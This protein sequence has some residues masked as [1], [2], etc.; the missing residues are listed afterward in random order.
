MRV[1]INALSARHGG[2]QTYLNYL[3]GQL[4]DCPAEVVYVLTHG[5]LDLPDHP[6]VKAIRPTWPALNPLARTVG[7]KLRLPR[8]LRDLSI[9]ILFCPGG[10][11]A[12]RPPPGC[13]VVSMFQNMLPFD[14]GQAFR[15]GFRLIT[16]RLVLLRRV[17]LDGMRKADLTIFISDHARDVIRALGGIRPQ[18]P[19]IPHGLSRQFK[20][21]PER[22]PPRSPAAPPRPY[23][24][25][26]SLLDP[27][28][29]HLEVVQ[30][31][32]LLRQRRPDV[33]DLV[34]VGKADTP[35][36]ASVRR[37]IQHAGLAHA[38]HVLG[39]V[40]HGD[41]PALHAHAVVNLFASSCE[42]CPN[43]LIEA[44]G[45]GRP[46]AVSD[47]QPMP[48]FALDAVEYFDPRSPA[49]IADALGRLL[50][51]PARAEALGG[52]ARA[53]AH[54]HDWQATARRTWDA[55]GGL[56]AAGRD[57]GTKRLGPHSPKKD[58]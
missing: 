13:L 24:L 35:H 23:I 55:L 11:I 16:L 26:V 28:K 8:L 31:Y 6:K 52:Q 57:P 9:D 51:D 19:V 39:Q 46:M 2:G 1:L 30:A 25:Y 37:A 34:F 53:L 41:L 54:R 5:D 15:Y 44:M 29:N 32:A 50:D 49:S 22:L 4:D 12:A 18:D 56:Y 17:L 14:L 20:I 42:N 58:G 27:Y 40:P 48:E 10:V 45:A 3:L 21:D 38:I 7:E 43:I 47:V 36:G 33:P